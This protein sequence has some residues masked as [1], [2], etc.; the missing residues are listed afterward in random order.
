MEKKG[1]ITIFLALILSLMLSLVATS[2]QSVQMAAAR[3]QILNSVDIGLY[4]LFGQYDKYLLKNYD[5]FFIDGAQGGSELNLASVY[6][7]FEKYM[8]PVLK[9]NS[10]NLTIKRGGFTGYRLA[11]DDDGEVFY[12]QVVTYMKETLETQGVSAIIDRYKDKT[13]D[14]KQAENSGKQAENGNT[15]ENYDSEMNSA[16]QKSE[17]LKEERD[18]AQSGGDDLDGDDLSAAGDATEVTV[19]PK[20]VNPIP[21]IQ[22]IRKMGLLDLIVPSEKGI[23]DKEVSYSNLMS[24]RNLNKGM[25]MA[26]DETKDDSATSKALFQQY[27]MK[28]LGSY[29]NPSSS[30]LSYQLEYIIGGKDNDRDNLKAVAERLLLIREGINL[31]CIMADVEKREEI[32]GLAVVIAAGFLVPPA[33]AV[34][35]AALLLCWSFAESILDLRE[36]FAGGKVAL[37]K[38]G[39]KWQLSLENLPDLMKNLDSSRKS[40]TDGMSYEDY[41][42]I[43]ILTKSK[44]EKIKMSMDMIESDIRGASG[45]ENFCMDNCIEALEIS[46]DVLANKKQTY[47]VTRQYSYS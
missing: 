18:K 19:A 21:I 14:V 7:N 29:T 24:H 12:R 30:G 31:S 41:L 37:L 11:S 22:N 39:A 9:Q 47:T 16:A 36:L 38:T 34:I 6:D 42:Q 20:V 4:S 45:R 44:S 46:V 28:H 13:D 35:E 33:A 40:D 15:L 26:S 5:L 10:Q 3:T 1:S 25:S 8:K 43:L 32:H 2:I 27:L 17:E 23:S